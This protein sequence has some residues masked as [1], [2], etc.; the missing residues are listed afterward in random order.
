M[1]G[2][3]WLLSS[4]KPADDPGHEDYSF[5]IDR[6]WFPQARNVK[7]SFWES[8]TSSWKTLNTEPSTLCE[9]YG[10]C[11]ANTICNILNPI[12]TCLNKFRR[13]V[14]GSKDCVRNIS[15]TCNKDKD[16]FKKYIGMVLPG[17][18]SS[19]YNKNMV[20]Q[21]CKDFVCKFGYKRWRKWLLA[22]PDYASTPSY[23]TKQKAI[24]FITICDFLVF[25]SSSTT[26][27][28]IKIFCQ[29]HHNYLRKE[30][31]DLPTF[32]L[33]VIAKATDNFSDTNKLGEGGFG[34]VYKIGKTAVKRLSNNSGQGL[35]EFINE[36]ALIAKLQ[37]HSLVKLHGYCIQ[38]EEKM[39]LYEY[40][41]N[42]SLD[43][44][45]FD[46]NRSKLLDWNMCFHIIGGIA[47]GPVYL[48]QDSRLRII[49]RDL[50]TSNILLDEN[51]NP[52]I[53]D[54]GLDRTLWGDQVDANTNKVAGT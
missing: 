23:L 16:G 44:F 49:H 3:E 47:R 30:E 42:K 9:S 25:L 15:L 54:F 46:E 45:I 32:D 52:K 26:L 31:P 24:C 43:Y 33:P 50:K 34:P 12:C 14:Y 29:S 28:M 19:W 5:K 51:M 10:T 18:S 40:M 1:K 48:H 36:V 17:T 27:G 38:E 11:G 22:L 13:Q 20:L 39:L 7:V 4:W 8:Q 2:E 21:E 41:P 37:H 53:S 6:R 35:K